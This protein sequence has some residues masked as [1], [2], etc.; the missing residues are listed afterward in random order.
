[1]EWHRVE[2]TSGVAEHPGVAATVARY[3]SL[4]STRMDAPLGRSFLD[5]DARFDT[6][7]TKESAA[8]NLLGDVMRLG[9]DADAAFMNGGTI[10]SDREFTALLDGRVFMPCRYVCMLG[11]LR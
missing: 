9:L 8:G 3:Q 7:R 11:M 4:V 2:V 10:R 5:L 6:V 1:M